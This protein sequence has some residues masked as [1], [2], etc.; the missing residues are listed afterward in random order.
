MVVS[1]LTWSICNT[2]VILI[3]MMS[4]WSISGAYLLW[5]LFLATLPLCFAFLS[6]QFATAHVCVRVILGLAWLLFLP[7]APYII[8]DVVHLSDHTST[9]TWLNILV[10]FSFALNGLLYGVYSIILM[11]N[12]FLRDKPILCTRGLLALVSMLCGYGVYIGRFL[13]WSSWSILTNPLALLQ[14]STLHLSYATAWTFLVAVGAIIF[15]LTIFFDSLS[16]AGHVTKHW[17]TLE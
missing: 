5:N 10:F 1:L 3:H 8:T 12:K 6:M 15:L 11:K 2:A 9:N 4:S 13:R 7:N 17:H 14:Q 16:L